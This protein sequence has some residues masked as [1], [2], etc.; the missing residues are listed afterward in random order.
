MPTAPSPAGT[1]ATTRWLRMSITEID[2]LS[3]LETKTRPIA[4]TATTP[5]G[6]RPTGTVAT[7]R[8]A[9]RSTTETSWLPWLVM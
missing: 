2:L 6:E 7:T 9:A 8:L 1:L 4:L 3:G 5:A